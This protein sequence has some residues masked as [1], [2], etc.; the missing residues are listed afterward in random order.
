MINLALETKDKEWFNQ[1]TNE[2]N[3]LEKEDDTEIDL[4]NPKSDYEGYYND[5]FEYEHYICQTDCDLV[6]GQALAIIDNKIYGNINNQE[7]FNKVEV[8][9]QLKENKTYKNGDKIPKLE[10]KMCD[11]NLLCT[12]LWLLGYLGGQADVENYCNIIKQENELLDKEVE[13]L[14]EYNDLLKSELGRLQSDYFAN[15]EKKKFK[16]K[17]WKK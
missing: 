4:F 7:T 8:I 9:V 16:W 1:L 12:A 14:K 13:S 15:K 10:L 17:F 6:E 5:L 11:D 3:K 2:L